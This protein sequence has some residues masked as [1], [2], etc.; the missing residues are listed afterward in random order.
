MSA[1]RASR[2]LDSVMPWQLLNSTRSHWPAAFL[3]R[4]CKVAVAAVPFVVLAFPTSAQN[5]KSVD[6]VLRA[7]TKVYAQL[8]TNAADPVNP[9]IAIFEGA[10]PSAV[11]ALDPFSAFLTP[12]RFSQL[13]E[14]QTSRE[15][16][17]GSIVSVLPGRIT[18]LQVLPATPMSRA[19]IEPGDELIA[20]NNYLIQ[21]LDNEQI[22]QLL[23]EARHGSVNVVVRRQGSDRP[24]HFTLTPQEM[25][26]RSVDRAFLLGDHIAYIRIK[27]F[28]GETARQFRDALEQL[29]G[30]K[31]RGLILDLRDNRGGVVDAALDVS[32]FLLPPNS[33]ILSA[34]GRAQPPVVERVPT[35]AKPYNFPVAVLING[36]TASAAEIVAGALRDHRRATLLGERSYGKGLVQQV[37]PLS[38]G[39]G[40]ALTTAYYFTPSGA[41]IQ[42]PLAGSQVKSQAEP[43]SA[44]APGGIAPD[45]VVQPFA[46][47]QFRYVLEGTGSFA[48]FATEYLRDRAAHAGK[49]TERFEIDGAILDEFQFF[50]SQRNIRPSLSM[51]TANSDYIRIRLKTEIFNQGLGVEYGEKIEAQLD[52]GIERALE[53]LSKATSQ[54]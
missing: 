43:G 26:S 48:S 51:W 47:N 44:G 46:T 15:K 8:E 27:S 38:M 28:E 10:L 41:S 9:E 17:F 33:V 1:A 21:A 39:T 2:T 35:S 12:D 7:F 4:I 18:V 53:I 42:R 37:L 54:P 31:V 6:D 45:E 24:L 30:D 13:R 5:Q 23:G 16:G 22:L 32:S 25:D 11:R 19:G 40:L 3:Y 50:L 49:L 20:V 29:G 52:S 34:Q 14:M 36:Q